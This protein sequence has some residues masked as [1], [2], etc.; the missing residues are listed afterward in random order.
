MKEGDKLLVSDGAGRAWETEIKSISRNGIELDV[1]SERPYEDEEVTRITLYQGIPKGAKMDDIV[2][3]A[4]EL[5]VY[6]IL[7]V[8]TARSVSGKE[9]VS[10][11]KLERWNRIAK[12]ASRQSGRLLVP[13]IEEA[14]GFEGAAAGLEREGFDLKL[15]LFELEDERTL[16]QALREFSARPAKSGGVP[17]IAVFVGPEGG[18]ENEEVDLLAREKV[19]SVTVG[20]TILRTETAGPAAVAMILYELEL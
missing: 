15:V 9:G 6:R 13:R 5:G 18:F 1:L 17:K 12:E 11:A 14:S 10:A 19:E 3:K 16:K 7:P 8:V 20:E 4:T 2:R